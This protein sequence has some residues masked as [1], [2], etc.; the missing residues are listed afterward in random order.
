MKRKVIMAFLVLSLVGMTACGTQNDS[1]KSASNSVA[2]SESATSDSDNE[3]KKADGN[4]KN[5]D[6]NGDGEV[7]SEDESIQNALNLGTYKEDI[8][9]EGDNR[10]KAKVVKNDNKLLLP[11]GKVVSVTYKTL[12]SEETF[13][14]TDSEKIKNL[15]EV[16]EKTEL[17]GEKDID[18]VV[19][20][21][22]DENS[23][24]NAYLTLTILNGDG[25]YESVQ[26]F[27]YIADIVWVSFD[28]ETELLMPNKELADLV[29]EYSD[30]KECSKEQLKNI[31]EISIISDGDEIE[32]KADDVK[33][34]ADKLPELSR[35]QEYHGEGDVINLLAKTKDNE[36]IHMLFAS[37]DKELV[38][39]SALYEADDEIA[40]I[41][42]NVEK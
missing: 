37:G 42:T 10:D 19:D 15:I 36:E 29:R 21:E 26:L 31:T 17:K 39:E 5:E 1:V 3:D 32:L 12:L 38:I 27:S 28:G 16:L 2:E 22:Y 41:L 8:K 14:D 33:K 35:H 4:V 13:L 18:S 24:D 34:I 6:L 30:Y 9:I 23:S 40:D 11:Q 7:N 20:G 25:K